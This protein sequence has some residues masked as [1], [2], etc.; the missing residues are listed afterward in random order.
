MSDTVLTTAKVETTESGFVSCLEESVE[1]EL[2]KMTPV[3]KLITK[4]VQ[5]DLCDW[6]WS[7]ERLEGDDILSLGNQVVEYL[8]LRRKVRMYNIVEELKHVSSL[9]FRFA[10]IREGAAR[11]GNP[12][13]VNTSQMRQVS[14]DI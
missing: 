5:R 7:H 10:L 13:K 2:D 9:Q 3:N 11:S 12:L 4:S 14:A 8:I 1:R 6:V